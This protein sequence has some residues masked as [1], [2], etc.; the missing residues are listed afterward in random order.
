MPTLKSRPRSKLAHGVITCT[1]TA[2][3]AGNPLSGQRLTSFRT[4]FSGDFNL[5]IGVKTTSDLRAET[6][7]FRVWMFVSAHLPYRS[8]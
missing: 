5:F 7:Q 1:V 6:A 4:A 8:G 2:H 3:C